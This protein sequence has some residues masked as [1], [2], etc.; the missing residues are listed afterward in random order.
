MLANVEE[1]LG[2]NDAIKVETLV[3]EFFAQQDLKILPRAPFGDAV[4]L[5]ATKDDKGAIEVFVADSLTTQVKEL[6]KLSD[7]KIKEGLD[8]H[9]EE[10]RKVMEKEF[11]SG[12]GKQRR[13]VR[14]KERPDGW[15]SDLDGHWTAQPGVLEEAPPSPEPGRSNK[16]QPTSGVAFSDDDDDDEMFVDNPAPAPPK[17]KAPAKRAAAPKKAPAAK[18]A[19]PARKAPARGRKTANPFVDSQAEEEE[20]DV[21]MEDDDEPLVVPAPKTRA[22]RATTT[23]AAPKTTRQTTLNFSQSQAKPSQRSQKAIEISDDE[24]SDDAFESMPPARS[25][26]R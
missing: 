23:R 26:R 18:K 6:L 19:A 5:F 8:A 12:Q 13:R 9:M 20:D 16:R 14:Y 1:S 2:G 15:D 21:I 25:R 24:I 22:S 10:Y 3:D 17:P 4:D 7:D 11:V